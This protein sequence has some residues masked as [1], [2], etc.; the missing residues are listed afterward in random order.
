VAAT[1]EEL[2]SPSGRRHNEHFGTDNEARLVGKQKA[3]DP[4]NLLGREE[5]F[6]KRLGRVRCLK[7][8]WR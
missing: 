8:L 2:L 1:K 3:G 6:Q 5:A 7:A 4:G